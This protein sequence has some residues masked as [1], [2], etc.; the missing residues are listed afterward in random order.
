[1]TQKYIDKGS[2]YLERWHW[3]V[4][5]PFV[6]YGLEHDR[7]AEETAHLINFAQKQGYINI[8][9]MVFA[10]TLIHRVRKIAAE[11]KVELEF[12]EVSQFD[13]SKASGK[14]IYKPKPK[15]DRKSFNAAETQIVN[16]AILEAVNEDKT[17]NYVAALLNKAGRLS[18]KVTPRY[19]QNKSYSLPCDPLKIEPEW[20]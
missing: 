4:I 9:R 12:A 17:A 5:N 8:G 7:T 2:Q 1:M 19:I 18:R 13:L 3:A 6:I 15:T 11:C 16:S 10:D 20:K 14:K